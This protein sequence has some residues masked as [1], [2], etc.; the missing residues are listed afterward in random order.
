MVEMVNYLTKTQMWVAD[1]RVEEY[2]AAGHWLA[3]VPGTAPAEV[4]EVKEPKKRSTKK[5]KSEE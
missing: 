2:K 1:D 5:K 3:A 4:E